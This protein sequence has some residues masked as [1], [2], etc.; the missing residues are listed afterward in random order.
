MEQF[1]AHG[2]IVF[3]VVGPVLL[4]KIGDFYA[5]A[6]YDLALIGVFDACDQAQQRRLSCSVG[7]DKTGFFA[8]E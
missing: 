6:P 5:L 2:S 8:F 1:I 7:T 3:G 4:R